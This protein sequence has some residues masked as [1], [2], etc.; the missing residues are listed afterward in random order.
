[1]RPRLR[2]VPVG[3]LIRRAALY[4]GVF[5]SSRGWRAVAVVVFGGRFLLRTLGRSEEV[6]SLERLRPGQSVTITA[7]RPE[8]RR[9]RR[10]A[11]S[12]GSGRSAA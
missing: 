7:I 6:V 9:D 4:R 3:Y 2:P 5:G 10:R 11:R 12:A 1:M 8:T